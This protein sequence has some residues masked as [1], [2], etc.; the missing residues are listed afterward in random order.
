[1][2][3]PAE[4][5]DDVTQCPVVDVEN[6]LPHDAV[7]VKIERVALKDVVVDECG[8]KVMRR[9]DGV[10]VSRKVEVDVLHGDDL[11]IAAA[12]RTALHAEAWAE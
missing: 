11:C 4:P 2:D 9:R 10:K 12:R 1:M 8:E 6:A 7:H 3:A 5:R